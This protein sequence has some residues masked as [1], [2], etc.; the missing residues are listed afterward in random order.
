MEYLSVAPCGVICELCIT[1]Q[2]DKNKCVGCNNT[3]YKPNHCKSCSIKSCIEKKGN[4]K[5]L[6]NECA[7]FPCR[8]IKDLDK[9]YKDK[10][11]ESNILNLKKI[12]EIGLESFVE[13]EG[14]KWKCIECGNLLC[15]HSDI[16]LKCGAN[17]IRGLK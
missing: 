11:G 2:R 13:T 15:V 16:C 5:L 3:G 7:K 8:R 12:S 14:T 17:N 10:Y 1:F 9:R 4:E 6:C